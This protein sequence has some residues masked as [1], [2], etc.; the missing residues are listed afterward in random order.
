LVLDGQIQAMHISLAS[1]SGINQRRA[2]GGSGMQ[3]NVA[4]AFSLPASMPR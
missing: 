1:G 4:A 2:A 3:Q